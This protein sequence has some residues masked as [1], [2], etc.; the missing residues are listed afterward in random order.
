MR[1]QRP[2]CPIENPNASAALE[3][4][5]LQR[6]VSCEP[7]SLEQLQACAVPQELRARFK[8]NCRRD[9]RGGGRGGMVR[10]EEEEEEDKEEEE[11]E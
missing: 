3:K 8:C 1:E 7:A 9:L 6:R 11:E 10:G 5:P 2:Q 4:P